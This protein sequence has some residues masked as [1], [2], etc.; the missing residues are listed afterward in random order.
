MVAANP[1]FEVV[2]GWLNAKG[3][4]FENRLRFHSHSVVRDP[5]GALLDVTLNASDPNYAFVLH[6]FDDAHFR[7]QVSGRIA[8]VDHMLGP[9]PEISLDLAV[10]DPKLD[11]RQF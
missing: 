7:E 5:T 10:E 1:G 6:P 11:N 9:D 4:T 8:M 2:H 3:E